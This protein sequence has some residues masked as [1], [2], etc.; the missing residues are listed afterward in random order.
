M[1]DLKVVLFDV[2]G[3]LLDS[4]TPHLKICEDK[5]IEYGLGLKIPDATEFKKMVRRGVKISPMKYFFMAVGF[6]EEFAE[7]AN[8]QYQRIFMQAYAPAPFPGVHETLRALCN[9]GR[10]LGI[11]TSN[12]RSN[13]VEALGPSSTFFRP[14]CIYAKDDMADLSKSQ[15]ITSAMNKFQCSPRETIYVGDQPADWEAA[16]AAGVKF[17]G[18][19][20]GWGISEDDKGFPI[21]REVREIYRY[22]LDC[23]TAIA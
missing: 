7:K 19:A 13:V 11:V 14:D 4:L 21:V 12:V 6:P 3:V 16:K 23:A 5:S 18:V 17:L 9:A 22:V 2:D 20:Y 10:Q 8:Q 1:S 15:A